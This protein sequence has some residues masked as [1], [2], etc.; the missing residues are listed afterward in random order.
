MAKEEIMDRQQLKP[1]V[2]LA[3]QVGSTD[4]FIDK[5]RQIT[6]V[7]YEVSEWFQQEYGAGGMLSVE[8]ASADFIEDVEN[9]KFEFIINPYLYRRSEY[10]F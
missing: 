8:R 2:K 5:V 9:G 7:S 4:E 6:N 1:F 10:F 3:K